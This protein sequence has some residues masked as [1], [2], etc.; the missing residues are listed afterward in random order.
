M[1][2]GLTSVVRK[3]C[4]C[5]KQQIAPFENK[6]GIS[7]SGSRHSPY[8]ALLAKSFTAVEAVAAYG[9]VTTVVS[10]PALEEARRARSGVFSSVSLPV[11]IASLQQQQI[12]PYS[13]SIFVPASQQFS[14]NFSGALVFLW[15]NRNDLNIRDRGKEGKLWVLGEGRAECGQGEEGDGETF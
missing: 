2:T 11:H 15:R 8:S 12:L 1:A 5:Q 6:I 3:P 9:G 10:P 4:Q 14:R 7:C 13:V